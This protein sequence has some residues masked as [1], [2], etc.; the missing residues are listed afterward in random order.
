MSVQ[1][2]WRK[3]GEIYNPKMSKK[4]VKKA[5]EAEAKRDLAQMEIQAEARIAAERD[6]QRQRKAAAEMVRKGLVNVPSVYASLSGEQKLTALTDLLER[7][8]RVM[9]HA[10]RRLSRKRKA[11]EW[12]QEEKRRQLKAA[13]MLQARARRRRLRRFVGY[14]GDVDEENRPNGRGR[15]V[16]W[17][18]STYEGEWRAGV[19]EGHG[20]IVWA[21][22]SSYVGEWRQ[23]LQHGRG[24]LEDVEGCTHDGEW[25]ENRLHGQATRT[26]ADGSVMEGSWE[27]GVLNGQGSHRQRDLLK[28]YGLLEWHETYRG[29]YRKG[30]RHGHGVETTNHGTYSGQWEDGLRHGIGKYDQT[31][32][33]TMGW[34]YRG[35]YREGQRHGHGVL[36]STQGHY[37]SGEWQSDHLPYGELT[38]RWVG[39][40]V[41]EFAPTNECPEWPLNREGRG[42]WD[43]V[44]GEHYEGQWK[45]DYYHGVGTLKT[46]AN[47]YDG[48]FERGMR[49]GFGVL[50]STNGEWYEGEFAFDKFDGEGQRS[51]ATGVY[52][53][54]FYEGKRHG[55]G[56]FTSHGGVRQVG[57]WR[58][59]V[60]EGEAEQKY[61]D[62]SNFKG[63]FSHDFKAGNGA[64]KD[65]LSRKEAPIAY[66]GGYRDGVRHGDTAEWDGVYGDH[67]HGGFADG[68]MRGV[69]QFHFGD[70]EEYLGMWLV[71]GAPGQMPRRMS[72]MKRHAVAGGQG[73]DKLVQPPRPSVREPSSARVPL[74]EMPAAIEAL[75]KELVACGLELAGRPAEAK[76]KAGTSMRIVAGLQGL[77]ARARRK[78][79]YV[80][81]GLKKQLD[82][83]EDVH[84]QMAVVPQQNPFAAE[85]TGSGVVLMS[86]Y[87]GGTGVVEHGPPS[88]VPQNQPETATAHAL[89]GASQIGSLSQPQAASQSYQPVPPPVAKAGGTPSPRGRQNKWQ[90]AAVL[91]KNVN[92]FAML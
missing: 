22:G 21:D 55:M 26:L 15:M 90:K 64:F 27:A 80:E 59:G 78:G 6:K 30:R 35:R 76:A 54:E 39:H 77:Q 58:H 87:A 48:A 89:R 40:Y 28:R 85:A 62:G 57:E 7:S 72:A 60:R 20:E 73:A 11:R 1:E 38:G 42:V 32:R 14:R 34:S 66:N 88:R 51:D 74:T 3:D 65:G 43:G 50:V 17:N 5:Q 81:P 45:E 2:E 25:Q 69:G 75:K 53:G 49:H 4:E 29:E 86:S 44:S 31:E 37:F 46:R 71:P 91:A 33:Q 16:F 63:T 84:R 12:V 36:S 70:G 92:V 13:N 61:P 56:A 8:A 18:A 82:A 83:A 41:G 9:V 47:V 10:F 67:Y 79:Q 24:V 68:E 19:F 23:G 52:T